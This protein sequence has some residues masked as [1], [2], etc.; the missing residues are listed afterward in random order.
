M[1]G[2]VKY[3]FSDN[4]FTLNS[5]DIKKFLEAVKE[6]NLKTYFK[7]QDLAIDAEENNVKVLS[8]NKFVEQVKGKNVFVFFYAPWCGH[9]KSSKPE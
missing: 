4:G 8:G 9:C 2:K 1:K 7:S 6:G 5:T 3:R